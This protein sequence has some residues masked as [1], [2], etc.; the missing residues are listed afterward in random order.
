MT[1][2]CA[3]RGISRETFYQLQRRRDAGEERWY[4]ALSQAP[5][6]RPHAVAPKVV[7]RIVALRQKFVHFGPRT[8]VAECARACRAGSLDDR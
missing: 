1:G 3:R 7:D 6:T 5:Q 8:S 2:L 4:E